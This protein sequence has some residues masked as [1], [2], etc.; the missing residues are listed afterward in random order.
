MLA[1]ALL[2]LGLAS[3]AFADY[4]ASPNYQV[5]ETQFG[6]GSGLHDCSTNYCA[7]TSLGEITVGGGSSTNYSAQFGFNT[8]NEPLLEIITTGGIQE[9][10]VLDTTTTATASGQIKIRNYLSSGYV[11]EVVGSTPGMGSHNLT[12]LSTPTSSHAGAEQFGINF[13]ANSNPSVGADPVQVPNSSFS[14]GTVEPD[15]ATANLF[16]YIDGD[17]VARSSSSSGETDYTMSIMINISNVTAGGHYSG[18]FSAVVVPT[19]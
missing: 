11:V 17:I 19:Y 9:L 18:T 2:P 16:K 14:Y 13:V 12:P 7:K 1:I 6:A 3:T 15:Y 8:T 10:G 4:S 5:N